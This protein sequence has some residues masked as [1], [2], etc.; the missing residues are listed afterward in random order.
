VRLIETAAGRELATLAAPEQYPIRCLCFRPDVE[1]LAAATGSR[2]LQV[3]DL[4]RIRKRLAEMGLDW[5]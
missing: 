1:Q 2:V 5:E 3:W 4:R